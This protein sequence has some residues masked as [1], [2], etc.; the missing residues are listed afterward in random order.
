MEKCSSLFGPFVSYNEKSFSTLTSGANYKKYLF[1][2]TYEWPNKL[3][4]LSVASLS[5]F[6]LSLMF[7]NRAKAY[8]SEEHFSCSSLGKAFGLT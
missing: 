1:F 4:S 6:K 3:D 5:S 2:I 7:A 8:P